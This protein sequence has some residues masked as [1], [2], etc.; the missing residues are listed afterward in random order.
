M[1]KSLLRDRLLLILLTLAII[2]KL[3]SLREDWVER[4]YTY[5]LYPVLSTLMRF[6][7]GWIPFSIGDIF[8]M[9]AFLFLVFKTWKLVR[10]LAKRQVKEYLSWILFRKYLKLVLWIYLV[11]NI[12]WGLNY[13]RRGIASQLQLKVEP[14]SKEDLFHLT[15]L[16]QQK[17]N[18]YAASEDSL[19]RLT[20][21]HNAFLFSE[22]VRNY[23]TVCQQYPFLN[24]AFPSI[25]PSLFSSVGHYFGFSG[26]FNPFTAEAQINTTEPV[27]NK[28][29]VIGHE[30]AHQLGYG[31]ENEASFVSYLAAKN[32]DNN[33]FRYSVYYE[34]FFNAFI[35]C[36]M[37]RDTVRTNAMR[38]A[39]HPRAR[40]DKL[41]ELQF[42]LKKKNRLQ[43]FVSDFYNGYLKINNQP[44]GLATYNE[45]TA[46]LVAYMKRYG[47]EAL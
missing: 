43:P 37:T 2:L 18:L 41:E 7:A 25:K 10:L 44:R 12:A 36:V 32:S 8:Y 16:L 34:L 29:F 4:Y 14:Y 23:D 45:V 39:L 33:D 11:F 47:D 28:P 20:L 27:F 13:D 35:E 1:L 38:N 31:K 21:E 15:S 3:C 5:G 22:G 9:V 46:W 30:I 17:L 26:Y 24:Y 42:R 40:L 6:L 19:K